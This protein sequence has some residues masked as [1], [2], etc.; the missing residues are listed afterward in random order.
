MRHNPTSVYIDPRLAQ[1]EWELF[2]RNHTHLLG[3]S[4]DLPT[5]DSFFTSN[6]L[7]SPIICTRNAEGEFKAF[8]NV[9]RHRGVVVETRARGEARAFTCPFHGWTYSNEGALIGLPKP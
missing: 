6:D 8:L 3:L 1:Q 9:C 2:F 4:G 5:N 7:G